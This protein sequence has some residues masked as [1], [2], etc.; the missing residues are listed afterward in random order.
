MSAV[1]LFVPSFFIPINSHDISRDLEEARRKKGREEAEV[2][3][4]KRESKISG[5]S[6]YLVCGFPMIEQVGIHAVWPMDN[7]LCFSTNKCRPN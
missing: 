1:P 3:S 6:S 7:W 2:K 4:L 5:H